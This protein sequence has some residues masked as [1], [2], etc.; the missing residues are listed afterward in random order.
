MR[1]SLLL[2]TSV[3]PDPVLP[4]FSSPLDATGSPIVPN[5]FPISSSDLLRYLDGSLPVPSVG[6]CDSVYNDID[7]SAVTPYAKDVFQAMEAIKARNTL[8]N[9][10]SSSDVESDV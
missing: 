4:K 3:R 2:R 9:T 6:A 1:T 8:A 7:S 10:L 5:Q